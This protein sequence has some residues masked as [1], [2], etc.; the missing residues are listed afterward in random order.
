MLDRV[1]EVKDNK[2]CILGDFLALQTRSG[3]SIING[4]WVIDRPGTYFALGTQ[5][6]YKRPN[7]IR[8][9][10][11]ESIAAPGPL[12]DDLHLYVRCKTTNI[13]DMQLLS[14]PGFCC[15][16]VKF[17]TTGLKLKSNHVH[18]I[19]TKNNIYLFGHF[20][21]W[22]VTY[23]L[24]FAFPL[25]LAVS[26]DIGEWSEC[27]RKCGPGSQLR[28]VI[29]RQVTRVHANRTETAVAVAPERC[30]SSERPATQSTCQLKIC[31][32]WEIRSDWSPCSVPCGVGQRSREVVCVGNHGL[33]D[34]EHECNM[35]LKPDFLQ[36][37]DM[38]VCAKSW[39]TS[40][41]S[42]R[43]RKLCLKKVCVDG[44]TTQR[45]LNSLSVLQS[46][47]EEI[48]P[49]RSCVS[50]IVGL[51]SRW[52]A[53][54][55]TPP[56]VTSCDAGPCQNQLEWYTGPWSQVTLMVTLK[57]E[58]NSS[59]SL[60][61]MCG[62]SVLQNVEMA[63]RPAVRFAFSPT[64]LNRR[65]WIRSDVPVCLSQSHR[66][67]ACSRSCNSGYR[68]REVRCLT[69]DIVPS[70]DCQPTLIPESQEECNKQPCL[71]ETNPLCS[72]QFHNC[73]LVVQ[74]RLCVYPYYRRVCCSSCSR[75]QRT[76]PMSMQR[77]R[78]HR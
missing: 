29:C 69:D 41:W 31:S 24:T 45:C 67:H 35:S 42:Q 76:Y 46:V 39:F 15:K 58:Q 70:D 26:W 63:H 4:N 64:T 66:S 1:C 78:I 6:I 51:T 33:V 75:T 3:I 13:S 19:Q 68:V 65:L 40:L 23:S 71:T 21:Y 17:G 22:M 11:G 37:C 43:V 48:K 52:M 34:E 38:G 16:L 25:C 53:V 72:D 57:V 28:Q 50:S 36:N 30:S 77:S 59:A 73:V 7:E 14:V 47:A 61:S 27:S 74:A 2:W 44:G 9:R 18:K 55:G 62:V 54:K 8:S 56:D 10:S 20:I 32:Q 49:D 60:L 12:T 5:M